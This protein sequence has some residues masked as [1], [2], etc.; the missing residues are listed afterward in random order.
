M[1]LPVLAKLKKELTDLKHELT[2]QIPK[3]LQTAAAHG[4]LSENAEYEA[5]KN[6]QDF[7]RSRIGHLEGRIRDLSMYTVASIPRGVVA[8][9]S[10][11]TVADV[12]ADSD[13]SINYM[14]VFPEEVDAAKGQISL[15]SPIGQALMS[16]TVGDEVEVHTPSGKR[17]YQI[18]DLVTFHEI[19]EARSES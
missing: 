4:D 19:R 9:G 13:V 15:S 16:K 8:Y 6:R 3:D 2:F 12:D 18:I 11:V 17:T 1:E 7:V 14:I 10:R 5:A